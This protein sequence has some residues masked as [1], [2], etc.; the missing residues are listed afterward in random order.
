MA[1][2]EQIATEV[3]TIGKYL[4]QIVSFRR[5]MQFHGTF[6]CLPLKVQEPHQGALAGAA[7]ADHAKC[8][9]AKQVKGDV[10]AGHH[11][12]AVGTEIGI[13]FRPGGI[14]AAVT[15]LTKPF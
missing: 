15:S 6:I 9:V 13:L 14:Q 2:T 10:V 7:L 3:R 8:F 11:G 5:A 12:T 4:R 1:Q